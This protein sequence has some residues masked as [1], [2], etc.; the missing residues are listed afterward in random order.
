MQQGR[1]RLIWNEIFEKMLRITRRASSNTSITK[2][3]LRKMLAPYSVEQ[4]LIATQAAEKAEMP[5]LL[6]SSLSDPGDQ[7]QGLEIRGLSLD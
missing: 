6:Q 4:W 5:F 7:G 2:E 3:I 1:P